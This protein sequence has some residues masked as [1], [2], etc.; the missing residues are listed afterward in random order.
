MSEEKGLAVLL[1]AHE[2]EF[3]L[4]ASK[5]M[6]VP[7]LLAVMTQASMRIPKLAECTQ[8]S[9]LEACRKMAECGTDRIGAGGMWLIPF[10]NNKTGKVELSAWPDWRLLIANAKKAGAIKHASPDVVYANDVFSYKRGLHRDL[11]HEPAFNEKGERGKPIAVYCVYELPDGE[12]DFA[13]MTWGEVEDI[14]GR[15]A[16]WKAYLKYKTSN[17]WVTDPAEMAKKTVV[18]RALKIFEGASAELSSTIAIDNSANGFNDLELPEPIAEP[19]AIDAP[20]TTLPTEEKAEVKAEAPPAGDL[21][22]GGQADG[23]DKPAVTKQSTDEE[24]QTQVLEWAQALTGADPDKMEG[25]FVEW[26]NFIPKK[27]KEGKL[28]PEADRKEKPGRKNVFDYKG[29]YLNVV[30][31]KAEAAYYGWKNK[32]VQ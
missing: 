6:S 21:S 32:E 10:N 4:I 1:K 29:N 8:I 2:K 14:R 27:T 22:Q 31:E 20:A 3:R 26:G 19:K 9:I 11:I 13:V 15:G 25:L 30:F 18:K 7:R 24:K 16:A 23:A 28:I 12:L 17:P 5:Y